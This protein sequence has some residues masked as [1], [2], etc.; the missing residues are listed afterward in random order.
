MLKKGVI[1][2]DID[3]VLLKAP[4][5]HHDW[6]D[7]LTHEER[8]L[9]RATVEAPE[10]QDCLCGRL[11]VGLLLEKKAEELGLGLEAIARV[12]HAWHDKTL[13][14]D[15]PVHR[16]LRT[17]RAKGWHTL[18]A[19]NQDTARAAWVKLNLGVEDVVD[20]WHFSCK[21]GIAKPEAGFFDILNTR[22]ASEGLPIVMIDDCLPN[23]DAP[24]RM[25][26]KTHHFSS[27]AKLKVFLNSL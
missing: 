7:S 11:G 21:A 26:W 12:L 4:T 1:C 15:E 24:A 13:T 22:Y 9:Y 27:E 19:S 23:L 2:W 17:M 3:G 18:I 6:R 10:W 8:Q 20:E 25:G 14:P 16:L 5:K